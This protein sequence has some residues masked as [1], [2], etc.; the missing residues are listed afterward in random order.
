MSNKESIWDKND[1]LLMLSQIAKQ[2]AE[3]AVREKDG[4]I[5]FNYQ[6]AGT[7]IKAIEQCNKMCGYAT[8]EKEEKET[9]DLEQKLKLIQGEDF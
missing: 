3:S 2:A 1:A 6:I 5:V 9:I 7:A 8:P 4:E